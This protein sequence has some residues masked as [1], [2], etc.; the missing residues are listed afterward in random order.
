MQQMVRIG[1]F[2]GIVADKIPA[3]IH[4]FLMFQNCSAQKAARMGQSD[5]V[6]GIA[7]REQF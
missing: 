4:P 5:S 2:N 6:S 1:E 3:T 7:Q